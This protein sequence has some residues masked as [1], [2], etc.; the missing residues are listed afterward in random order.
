MNKI[1]YLDKEDIL[2]SHEMGMA[3]FGGDRFSLS[4]SCVENRVIEPQTRYFGEE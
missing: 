4:H 3:E 1:V 2:L